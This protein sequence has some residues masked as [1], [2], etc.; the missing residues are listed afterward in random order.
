MEPEELENQEEQKTEEKAQVGFGGRLKKLFTSLMKGGEPAE[1]AEEEP[2]EQPE[3]EEDDS[4]KPAEEKDPNL[5]PA[6][7]NPLY[8]LYA[9]W[10]GISEPKE[11][12]TFHLNLFMG[13]D[14]ELDKEKVGWLK[15]IEA[16]ARGMVKRV[17]EFK[18]AEQA[19]KADF[20]KWKQQ[21]LIPE[22]EKTEK[23]EKPVAPKEEPVPAKAYVKVAADRMSGWLFMLP[24]FFGGEDF[25]QQ[26]LKEILKQ[27]NLT[28]GVNEEDVAV[29]AQ[30]RK[31]FKMNQVAWGLPAQDGVDGFIVDHFHRDV[32]IRL[33]VKEDNTIDYKDLGWLQTVEEGGLICDIIP[34]TN[35]IPGM[36]VLGNEVR[37]RDGKKAIAPKGQNTRVDEQ[38]TALLATIEGVLSFVA[39]RFQ[40]DPLLII[41][42]D[43]DNAVGNLNVIGDLLVDGDVRE[44]Y[45][46]QASGNITIQGMVEGADVQAG[47]DIQVGCGMNGN[48]HGT[49]EAKGEI[50]CKFIENGTATAGSKIV[51]DTII[52]STI[53]SDSAIEVKTGRGAIIGGSV[54]ALHSIHALSIGNQSNRNIVI[55]MGSTANFLREKRE[56]EEKEKEVREGLQE[57]SKNI[58]YLTPALKENN[59]S[60][61]KT[62][63]DLNLKQ[64]VQ[65]MQLANLERQLVLMNK[66][67][68]D[69]TTCRMRAEVLYPPAQITIG[70]FSKIVREIAYNPVCF[71][72][73]GEVR[74]ANIGGTNPEELPDEML[75]LDE[76]PPIE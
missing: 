65:K 3:Q 72:K 14:V 5:L 58:I 38:E 75:L 74:I 63:D 50:R 37:G 24:P 46:V 7:G 53:S 19:Y 73:E 29:L 20:E 15:A 27:N 4:Q 52:N 64:T 49:L 23:M 51:C 21:A 36:N 54:T 55:N 68:T 44:G 60:V 47:K 12:D 41:R 43:V 28:Y 26:S 34:P 6:A 40:V 16:D 25:T 76:G 69:N 67:A 56:L 48:S 70:G 32:E 30:Y 42:G 10:K 2:L 35:A 8:K 9:Q 71:L 61:I 33:T 57:I 17:E 59:P 39:G 45:S 1:T 31:Y 13:Q 66:K 22:E 11:G 18:K 62:L